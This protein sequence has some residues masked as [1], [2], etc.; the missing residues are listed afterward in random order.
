MI[1]VV[2]QLR[3]R[4]FVEVEVEVKNDHIRAMETERKS[5]VSVSAAGKSKRSKVT[6]NQESGDPSSGGKQKVSK[7]EVVNATEKRSRKE[8]EGEDEYS[9]D[10]PSRVGYIKG[11]INRFYENT[12]KV[13]RKKLRA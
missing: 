5:K 11:A 8:L 6:E 1:D 2:H 10:A 4:G 13:K 3:D 7:K 9:R 12:K